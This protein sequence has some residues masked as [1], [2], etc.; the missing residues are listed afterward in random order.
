MYN[1][2]ICAAVL[3]V[4]FSVS[5]MAGC[6]NAGENTPGK[7]QSTETMTTQQPSETAGTETACDNTQ[8]LETEGTETVSGTE[9]QSPT[10]DI[11]GILHPPSIEAISHQINR[12]Y[13]PVFHGLGKNLPKAFV[14]V[15][16]KGPFPGF[17]D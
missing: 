13:D 15:S 11:Q 2:R 8:V 4:V 1:R 17:V 10:E 9:A 14:P 7:E 3:A 6:G 5:G 16:T 12:R